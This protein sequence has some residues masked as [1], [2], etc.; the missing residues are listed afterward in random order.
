[1]IYLDATRR[2]IHDA[3]TMTAAMFDVDGALEAYF[4]D[5]SR[6]NALMGFA[7]PDRFGSATF[8]ADVGGKPRRFGRRPT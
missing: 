8:Q 1:M 3:Q 2:R 6:R 7:R 5:C 4:R